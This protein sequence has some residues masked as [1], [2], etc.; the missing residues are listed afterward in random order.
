MNKDLKLFA[1]I[2]NKLT[3][4][5]TLDEYGSSRSQGIETY[6]ELFDELN[7]TGIVPPRGYW[8]ENS[9][10]IFLHRIKKK[11]SEETLQEICDIDFI[12]SN[13]WEYLSYTKG[14]EILSKGR[15][16][17]TPVRTE[18]KQSDPLYTY[19]DVEG[20]VWKEHEINELKY[21]DR[22][23]LRKVRFLKNNLKRKRHTCH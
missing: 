18:Y 10:K 21:E 23:I 20:L 5:T 12:G 6:E 16:H 1:E 9:L 17:K 8:T 3:F 7:K 19:D 2:T 22:K 14:N 11:Y 15:N 13:S 4:Y